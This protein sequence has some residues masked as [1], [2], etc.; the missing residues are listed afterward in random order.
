MKTL[1][2]IFTATMIIA[3]L[4]GTL[5]TI[6]VMSKNLD[7]HPEYSSANM[8]VIFEEVMHNA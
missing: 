6:E 4:W 8:W 1:S 2:K 7:P 5:S 3:L